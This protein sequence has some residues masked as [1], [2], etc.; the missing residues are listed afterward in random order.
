MRTLSATPAF[1]HA[2]TIVKELPRRSQHA[3]GAFPNNA[4]N[5]CSRD[6]A[7]KVLRLLRCNHTCTSPRPNRPGHHVSEEIV[8]AT[9]QGPLQE[10]RMCVYALP[11]D[12]EMLRRIQ[13]I[14]WLAGITGPSRVLG[15][16]SSLSLSVMVR[17]GKSGPPPSNRSS[18]RAEDNSS[19]C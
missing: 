4:L 2:R 17:A 15:T 7:S 1:S 6:A 13:V 9:S 8:R 5:A 12:S 11:S 16:D 10:T 18:E 14:G 19:M 3:R